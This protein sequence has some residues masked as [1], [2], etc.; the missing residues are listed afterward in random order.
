MRFRALYL[1]C[2]RLIL[3]CKP[4]DFLSSRKIAE[5]DQVVVILV[6]TPN[7]TLSISSMTADSEQ[8]PPTI[9]Q[10][11]LD[12]SGAGADEDLAC[13]QQE[14]DRARGTVISSFWA[15]APTTAK[16]TFKLRPFLHP[17]LGL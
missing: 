13:L 7:P 17:K 16:M 10:M 3:R 4:A 5:D 9:R 8:S 1:P 15:S 14:A 6:R 2:S 11:P 12:N